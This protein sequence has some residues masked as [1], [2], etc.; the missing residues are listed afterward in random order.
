MSYLIIILV[1]VV[2]LL[3]YYVYVLTTSA[4]IVASNLNLKNNPAA[5][6]STA[7][8]KPT[9]STYTVG[10]WI[11]INNFS[12]N[13]RTFLQFGN[14]ANSVGTS[15]GPLFALRMES[16]APIMYVDIAGKNAGADPNTDSMNTIKMTNNFPLQTWTYVTVSVSNYYADIYID[17]KLVI[18]S[19]LTYPSASSSGSDDPFFSFGAN[20]PD[21]YITGLARWPNPLDPQSVWSYYSKGNGN[22]TGMFGSTYHMDISLK[23]DST[24]YNYP[25]F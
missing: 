16:T 13:I 10:L 3:I 14:S 24:S 8:S 25:I 7:V 18:S 12:S 19:K 6:P 20:S 4:P 9:T 11:Y 23:R 21:M 22:P 2:V 5:L 17:G 1:I 15:G